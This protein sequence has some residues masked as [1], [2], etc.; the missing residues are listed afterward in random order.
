[1]N[2]KPFVGID[3]PQILEGDD[4]TSIVADVTFT[5]PTQEWQKKMCRRFGIDDCRHVRY[6]SSGESISHEFA[7]RE[8]KGDGNCMFRCLSFAV[9]NSE[10][11][12]QLLR[13][14]TV[15]HILINREAALEKFEFHSDIDS[16]TPEFTA[17]RVE[18]FNTHLEKMSIPGDGLAHWATTLE[19]IA[20]ASLLETDILMY[21][22]LT[23]SDD[24]EPRFGWQRYSCGLF[25]PIDNQSGIITP[26]S[27][28]MKNTRNFHY[29][30]V[31]GNIPNNS[32]N[33]SNSG[34]QKPIKSFTDPN[35]CRSCG[36]TFKK[37]GI[38]LSKNATCKKSSCKLGS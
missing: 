1:M 4:A 17:E 16:R 7:V 35:T 12:H 20:A 11:H 15:Q 34:I 18:A 3:V 6:K 19:V 21:Q 36:K 32:G 14:L 29:D 25:Q 10:E 26:C 2:L 37:L 30:L 38:H 22:N 33:P 13:T 23:G 31:I 8:I 28:F 27:I 24:G 5:P 9:A